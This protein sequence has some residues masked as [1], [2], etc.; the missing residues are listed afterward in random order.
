VSI[1]KEGEEGEESYS[2]EDAITSSKN[3]LEAVGYN[4]MQAVWVSVNSGTAYINFAYVKDGVILYPDLIKVKVSL[5]DL[6]L[7]GLEANNY[8]YNHVARTLSENRGNPQDISLKEGF[9]VVTKRLAVIPTEW[10]TEIEVYEVA[11]SYEG[12]FFYLYYDVVTLEQI[13]VMRVIED[14]NQGELIV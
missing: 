3:F 4:D 10:N 7:I 1:V 9:E 5:S 11:G 8:I 14:E 13:K 2:K 6:S 12:A